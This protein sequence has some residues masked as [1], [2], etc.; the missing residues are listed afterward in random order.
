MKRC[1]FALA[2][3]LLY[4]VLAGAAL[5]PGDFVTQG[6]TT[7]KRIALTFDDG[8]GPNTAKFLDLLDRYH[9][10]ATFFMLGDQARHRPAVAKD[11]ADRGHDV[12]SH[13]M[14]HIDYNKR[15]KYWLSQQV[16]LDAKEKATALAKA[17]LVRDMRDSRTVIE[18]ETGRKLVI[19]RM[20]HG[21]DRPWIKDAAK[22][23]GFVLVNWTYGADWSSTPAELLKQSYVRAIHPGAIILM[24]DGWPKSDKS[25]AVAEAVIQAAQKQGYEIVTVSELIGAAAPA[26]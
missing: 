18:K 22:Q 17:D 20:P 7:G 26:R 24:H 2:T 15:Y 5:K 12:G 14:T 6:P 10:K 16:G 3:L 11:V 4:C 25:L 9:V 23:T 8:P 1:I 13:T 21:I 19:L